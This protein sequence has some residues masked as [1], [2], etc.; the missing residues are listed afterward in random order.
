[1]DEKQMH[2]IA[3]AI[4]ASSVVARRKD[5]KLGETPNALAAVSEFQNVLREMS[6]LGLMGGHGNSRRKL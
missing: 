4:L 5:G 6:D 1:M 3:A 2:Y